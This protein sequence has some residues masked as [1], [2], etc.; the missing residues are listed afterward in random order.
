M[1]HFPF[2]SSTL[3]VCICSFPLFCVRHTIIESD[4]GNGDN[5][6]INDDGKQHS[7]PR[8]SGSTDDSQQ[9]SSNTKTKRIRDIVD[10]ENVVDATEK[11]SSKRSPKRPRQERPDATIDDLPQLK[12]EDLASI[13]SI[14]FNG[15]DFLKEEHALA[16]PHCAGISPIITGAFDKVKVTVM[17]NFWSQFFI[18]TKT[19]RRRPD[20]LNDLTLL[21]IAVHRSKNNVQN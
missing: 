7:V 17:R 6:N 20:M 8:D 1:T 16:A 2:L 9:R 15:H 13:K 3:T 5:Q 4:A 21:V 12:N 18:T 14:E 19:L 10:N 11:T